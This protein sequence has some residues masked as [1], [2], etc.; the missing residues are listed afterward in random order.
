[1]WLLLMFVWIALL[2]AVAAFAQQTFG[3]DFAQI[4]TLFLKLPIPQQF[5][6][7]IIVFLVA[8]RIRNMAI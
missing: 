8:D 5:I 1:M 7:G 4:S 6:A 2:S 3:L